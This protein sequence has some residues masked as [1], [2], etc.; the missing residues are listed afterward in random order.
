MIMTKSNQALQGIRPFIEEQMKIWNVPGL[1]V[2]VIRDQEIIMAEGFG[3]RDVEAGLEVTPETLFAI[4]STTKAFTATTAGILVDEGKIDLDMPV[5][6]YLPHFKM[7]DSLATERVTL[8]DMLCH[9]TGLPRHDLMWYNSSLSREDIIERIQY[10][11]PNQDFRSSWQYQNIMY[12]VAGFIVGQQLGTSWEQVVKDK[13]FAPLQMNASN[14]SVDVSQKQS[15]YALP[16]MDQGDKLQRIPFRNIDLISPAGS[17]NSNLLDMAKWVML[18]LN[19]GVHQGQR[20]ISEKILAEVFKPH[21]PTDSWITQETPMCCYSLGW[22]IE[23]YRGYQMIHHNGGIDGFTAEVAFSPDENLGVV[24]FANKN[25]SSLPRIVRHN[26]FDR[27]FGLDEID[28]SGRIRGT[29]KE[30]E[31]QDKTLQPEESKDQE[32]TKEPEIPPTHQLAAYTGTYEHPGYGELVIDTTESNLQVTF[33]SIQ[34]PLHR[35]NNHAFELEYTPFQVKTPATFHI[36]A[37][38]NI[39]RVT[40]KMLFEPGTKDIEF[41]KK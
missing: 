23:P 38:N 39:D 40:V 30:T 2:A 4:G 27:L 36:D 31:N 34:L 29:G 6:S 25:G 12:M 11:E 17:I 18:L 35:I 24:I 33:N 16:Y 28:W 26:L 1:A 37:S 14:L 3:Y 15:N 7:Y 5:K 9:R 32:I 21:M 19:K 10:L 13:I 8:R 41:V 22:C 20:I